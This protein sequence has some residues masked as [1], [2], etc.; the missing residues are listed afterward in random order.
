MVMEAG[1]DRAVSF[2]SRNEKKPWLYSNADSEIF[3]FRNN[4]SE[5]RNML[6]IT[7][8]SDVTSWSKRMIGDKD[9][10]YGTIPAENFSFLL[11]LSSSS[12]FY[13]WQF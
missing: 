12:V 5:I 9:S 11:L 6:L 10:Y 1:N 8:K 3:K 13:S 2:D 7:P 4:D